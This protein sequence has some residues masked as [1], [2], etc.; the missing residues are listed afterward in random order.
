MMT[1]GFFARISTTNL[2]GLQ[3]LL[4]RQAQLRVGVRA[5][6]PI[7]VEP[8]VH[9]AHLDQPIDPLLRQQIVDVRLAEAGADAGEDLVLEAVLH[10]LHRLAEARRPGR[11]ARR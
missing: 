11:G 4:R 10:A 7:D 1:I 9:H 5:H 8:G 6:R 3:L 2:P